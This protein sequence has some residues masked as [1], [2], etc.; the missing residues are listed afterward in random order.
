MPS[1]RE[2]DVK[3]ASLK[4]TRKMTKTMQMVSASKL[5]RAQDAQRKAFDY[6][7]HL[8]DLIHRL[9][10]SVESVAHP[11]LT[12]RD[13]VRKAHILLIT[14]DR[15]LCAG[16]NNNLIKH[17]AQWISEHNSDYESISMSCCGRRGNMYFR[18]KEDVRKE[19]PDTTDKPEFLKAE[20]IADELGELFVDGEFD[21]VYLAY[22]VFKSALS[23]Y[24]LIE[25]M[26][27][28]A[29][30]EIKSD[31]G[32]KPFTRNYIFEPTEPEL[33]ALLLPRSVAYA[34]F[35]AMVE[36]S[37]GEHGARMTA[38]DNATNNADNLI[39]TN[40]LLR[41]RARQAA[42]TTELIEIVAGAEAL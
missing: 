14:S 39:E 20:Q 33:L 21:E 23:Q 41:N 19:Y 31:E 34:I 8:H 12:A 29:P 5:R 15:G 10:G 37:A 13:P 42:I 26:L 27:P 3:I 38:M 22:N 4:N 2:Y 28:I 32:K 35:H 16:F 24:P 30:V 36:N 1:L 7:H 6:A 9:A 11:L 40:T 18:A 17:V 25:K